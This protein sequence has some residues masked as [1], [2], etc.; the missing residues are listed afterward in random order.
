MSVRRHIACCLGINLDTDNDERMFSSSTPKELQSAYL[1]V[2]DPAEGVAPTSDRIVQDIKKVVD[3]MIVIYNKKGV[4]VPGLAGGRT[5]GGRWTE[6]AEKT[7]NN[8]GGKRVKGAGEEL[9]EDQM[10][11]DLLALI[12]ESGDIT[13]HFQKKAP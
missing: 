7:S 6:T 11:H 2:T 8:H 9:K 10:H 4:F 3:S 13:E 12:E 1:R 5:A